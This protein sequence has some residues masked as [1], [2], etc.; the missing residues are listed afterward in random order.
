[1]NDFKDKL[2]A[3]SQRL[4]N[5]NQA[6]PIQEVR[7]VKKE[8]KETTVLTTIHLPEKIHKKIKMYCIQNGTTIKDFITETLT[9]SLE[10]HKNIKQ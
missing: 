10:G 5:A 2:D 1:M 8:K 3:F 9:N 7:P 6:A 4:V